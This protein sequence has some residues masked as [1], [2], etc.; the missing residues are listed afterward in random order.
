MKER[1]CQ[2]APKTDGYLTLKIVQ[3]PAKSPTVPLHHR[4]TGLLL[5]TLKS[6]AF[7]SIKNSRLPCLVR[8]LKVTLRGDM[9]K[10]DKIALMHTI[11]LSTMAILS[12]ITGIAGLTCIKASKMTF[13]NFIP[14]IMT[15][16]W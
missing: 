13:L 9:C 12:L 3:I 16:M 11:K 6:H 1:E 7:P 5:V 2:P 10:F 14:S 15:S 4:L 8:G